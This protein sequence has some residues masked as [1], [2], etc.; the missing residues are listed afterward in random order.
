MQEQISIGLFTF[1]IRWREPVKNCKCTVLLYPDASKDKYTDSDGSK[2]Y[3]KKVALID[4]SK[5]SVHNQLKKII[6]E[7]IK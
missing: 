4:E 3:I 7:A 2:L 6:K 5:E 1:K